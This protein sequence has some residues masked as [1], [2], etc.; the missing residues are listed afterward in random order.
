MERVSD[1]IAQFKL[2]SGPDV[3]IVLDQ[4]LSSTEDI[5]QMINVKGFMPVETQLLKTRVDI[6]IDDRTTVW[7]WM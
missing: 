1:K 6:T 7:T 4:L 5:S 3:T 2:G